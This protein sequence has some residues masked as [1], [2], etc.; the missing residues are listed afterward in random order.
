MVHAGPIHAAHL[1]S[2]R[3]NKSTEP[4]SPKTI[5]MKGASSVWDAVDADMHQPERSSYLPSTAPQPSALVHRPSWHLPPRLQL[6]AEPLRETASAPYLDKLS[7][8]PLPPRVSP[9]PRSSASTLGPYA[10][11]PFYGLPS[12]AAVAITSPPVPAASAE[13]AP[14]DDPFLSDF[15]M[16][17]AGGDQNWL[18]SPLSKQATAERAAPE[19]ALVIESGSEG[20]VEGGGDG[21]R[22]DSMVGL[23]VVGSGRTLAGLVHAASTSDWGI[24]QLRHIDSRNSHQGHRGQ[25]AALPPDPSTRA[26]AA[27][28]L[29]AHTSEGDDDAGRTHGRFLISKQGSSLPNPTGGRASVSSGPSVS[30][31]I[32]P[33]LQ[34][35]EEGEA[36]LG[37]AT[38]T[39]IVLNSSPLL[40]L[41]PPPNFLPVPICRGKPVLPPFP[42]RSATSPGDLP[43][44]HTG[45]RR[46]EA[47][48]GSEARLDA[49]G[50]YVA[51]SGSG[52]GSGSGSNDS[53]T[54]TVPPGDEDSEAP[55][56]EGAGPPGHEGSGPPGHEGSV[57]PGDEGSVPSGHEGSGPPGHEGSGPP[58]HEGS[59][60][61]GHEGSVPPGDEGSGTPGDEGELVDTIH[62]LDVPAYVSAHGRKGGPLPPS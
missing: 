30:M 23:E 49:V 3:S 59:V 27:T 39:P 38:E 54:R 10:D 50:R 8:V 11:S 41:P 60:P 32:D 24:L 6:H 18:M 37:D 61:P 55:D 45:G 21:S 12:T 19:W 35:S 7:A 1:A 33:R 57:P 13:V 31:V 28:L 9:T 44:G 2:V 5:G 17:A 34:S 58:G 29:P 36:S 26:S 16:A 48:S 22:G 15:Y 47:G 56:N 62:G 53:K 25:P 51:D 4:G 20:G 52:S 14:D 46:S 40:D 43:S 42:R